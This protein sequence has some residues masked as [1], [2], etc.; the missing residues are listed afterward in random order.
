MSLGHG[1]LIPIIGLDLYLD[2]INPRSY[3]GSGTSFN[4]LSTNR[5][6]HTLSAGVALTSQDGVQC[7]DCAATGRVI[8]RTSV[9]YT[10]PASYTMVSWARCLLDSQ[11][12]TWRTL[13]RHSS[14]TGNHPFLIQKTTGLAGMWISGT[15]RSFGYNIITAEL[16]AKWT[17][18]TI[19]SSGGSS[20]LFVNDVPVGNTI[21]Y[22]VAGGV[23][24][25][26]GNLGDSSN[27]QPWGY[28]ATGMLYN[29]A[30]SNNE[31]THLFNATRG[32]FG[33]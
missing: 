28:V 21:A 27:N 11:V 18:W 29:R 26:L 8:T 32:R 1:P 24:V 25:W 12:S 2:V 4:D 23:H 19:T 3:T 22:S 13:W 33:L 15:F 17:M 16:E 6:N 31:I 30:L 20:S 7:F 5:I 9:N 10:L 14:A